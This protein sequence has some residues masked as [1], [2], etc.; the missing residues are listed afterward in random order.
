MPG[1]FFMPST[2]S[3]TIINDGHSIAFLAETLFK[4]SSQNVFF[5]PPACTLFEVGLFSNHRY[6]P[7]IKL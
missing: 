5:L 2:K 4:Q 6:K 7:K 3:L 1:D